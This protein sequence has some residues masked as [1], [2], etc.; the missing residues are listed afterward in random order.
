ME[1]SNRQKK[2]AALLQ[3]DV[4]ALL[5]TAAKKQT[6]GLLISVTKVRVTRDLSEAKIYVSVFPSANREKVLEQI[7]QESVQ[8]RYQLG[9]KIRHQL[10]QVPQLFFYA[11]DSLEY[12]EHIE[13][14][15]KQKE[16]K[17]L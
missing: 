13:K 10:R 7:T 15:L 8:I 16:Q 17:I 3:K 5:Q 14:S 1:E 12:I 11:D 6:Q 4:A 2:V 9:R